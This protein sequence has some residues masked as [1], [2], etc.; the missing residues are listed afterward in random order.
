MP[1]FED[2]ETMVDLFGSLRRDGLL[3]STVY[4]SNIVEWVGMMGKR[5]EVW[6]EDGAIPE[7]RLKEL[8]KQLDIGYWTAKFG[9]YGPKAVIESHFDEL[10]K[11]V[12]EKAP[13]G[14]LQGD[15]FSGKNGALLEATDVP[16]PHGGFFVGVPSLWSLPM[17]QYRLPKDG[18]GIGAHIDYSPIIPSSGKEVL[19]WV[20]TAKAIC[21]AE[22]FDLFCDF[23]MHE[24][25]VIFVNFLTFDKTDAEQRRAIEAIFYNLLR[26]GKKKGYSKYRSHVNYMGKRWTTLL[27]I[28]AFRVPEY[29]N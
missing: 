7:W 9:M 29:G 14:R 15:V 19:E 25:H 10:K 5:V 22:N 1:E 8:Q 27:I 11:I 28:D 20:R 13:S 18:S 21:E 23:F 16:E 6:P 24:R 12:A 3:P 2:V 17:T 26:E 4:I